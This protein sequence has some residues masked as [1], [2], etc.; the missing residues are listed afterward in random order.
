MWVD[1]GSGWPSGYRRCSPAY[2][3]LRRSQALCAGPAK[4]FDIR[5]FVAKTVAGLRKARHRG[6]PRIG[7]QFS[8]AM[9]AYHLLRLPKLLGAAA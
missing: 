2:A 9:A 4:G 3:Q 1:P 7:W 6:L 8:L 5:E